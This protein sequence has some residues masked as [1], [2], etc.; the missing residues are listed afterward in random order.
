MSGV[1]KA[2][3]RQPEVRDVGEERQ[4][5]GLVGMTSGSTGSM[6]THTH[7]YIKIAFFF[8]LLSKG[9]LSKFLECANDTEALSSNL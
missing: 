2:G 7:I 8:S 9:I 4:S 1:P 5:D 6:D 3:Q